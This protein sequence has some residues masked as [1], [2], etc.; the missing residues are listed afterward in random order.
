MCRRFFNICYAAVSKKC[1]QKLNDGLVDSSYCITLPSV[2]LV[3]LYSVFM[4]GGGMVGE[5]VE[6]TQVSV[7]R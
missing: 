3:K 6:I 1:I 5:V 7:G 2:Q 4:G